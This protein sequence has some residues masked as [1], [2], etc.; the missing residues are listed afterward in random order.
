MGETVLDG[1]MTGQIHFNSHLWVVTD[2]ACRLASALTAGHDSTRPVEPPPPGHRADAVRAVPRARRLPAGPHRRAGKGAN[3]PRR[4][5]PRGLYGK[6][7]R[8]R[9]PR[10]RHSQRP[11]PRIRRSSPPRPREGRRLDPSL[12]WPRH[13]YRRRLGRRHRGRPRDGHRFRPRG[14]PW[15]LQADPATGS[16][17][18]LTQPR[19]AVLLHA[20]PSRVTS[21]ANRTKS[22]T[23]LVTQLVT[24]P[25]LRDGHCSSGLI[26]WNMMKSR[27]RPAIFFR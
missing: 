19:K 23:S 22:K 26:R 21:A 10:R 24:R 7:V 12:P 9:G 2:V 6:L 4:A 8:R 14:P 25:R 5:S 13:K 15:R 17:R 18:H 27:Y 20:P 11:A 3:A 16:H 1:R